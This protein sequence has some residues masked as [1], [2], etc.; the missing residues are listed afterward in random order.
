MIGKPMYHL[1]NYVTFSVTTEEKVGKIDIVDAYGTFEQAEEPSYDIFVEEEN[2]LYKH[3][4][5]SAVIGIKELSSYEG[6]SIPELE[7]DFHKQIDAYLEDC[8]K[9]G[10][11]AELP[12]KYDDKAYALAKANTKY[13]AEGKVV[14]ASDDEW[15]DET[16]WDDVYKQLKAEKNCN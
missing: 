2:C 4:P 10:I 13:N 12:Q 15:R 6:N 1:G 14:I 11:Q 3:I 16:E 9:R 7:E 5:E 8:N